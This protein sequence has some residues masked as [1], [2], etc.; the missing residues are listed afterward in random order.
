MKYFFHVLWINIAVGASTTVA[1]GQ[2]PPAL[3]FA[4]ARVGSPVKVDGLL[5]DQRGIRRRRFR[6]LTSISQV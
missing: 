6:C 4:A 5:H 1:S 3:T 2:T